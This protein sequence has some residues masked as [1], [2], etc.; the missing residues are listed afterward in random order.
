MT[1]FL[2]YPRSVQIDEVEAF[3]DPRALHY[4]KFWWCSLHTRPET[5]L[6]SSPGKPCMYVLPKSWLGIMLARKG[7]TRLYILIGSN[8]PPPLRSAP[9]PSARPRSRPVDY[10]KSI[11]YRHISP[12]SNSYAMLLLHRLIQC[13]EYPDGPE[14]VPTITIQTVKS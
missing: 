5:H 11:L 4:H 2:R 6:F 7:L 10:P 14:L 13:H 3:Q 9:Y 1:S 8:I 12:Y